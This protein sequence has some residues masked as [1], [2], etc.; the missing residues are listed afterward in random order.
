[1][2][3]PDPVLRSERLLLRPLTAAD[4]DLGRALL[5]DPEV[6][7]YM[8]G[9]YSAQRLEQEMA[10][11]TRRC[12]AGAIGV[13]C[14]LDAAGEE[15][16]GTGALLPLPIEA[17]DTEWDL[18]AG[19]ALPDR[20]IE[21]GY[22]LKREA[23]GRGYATEI[24]RRLLRFAFEETALDQVV[25]VVDPANEVSQKVL[26]KAGFSHEGWRRAYAAEVPG[27]RITRRQWLAG[28]V[29]QA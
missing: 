5:L 22:L 16:L 28:R 23:W 14:A 11:A 19:D 3:K 18:I 29:D 8:G 27:F 25:A 10:V 4:E 17:D 13:W 21:I 24:C 20:E 26:R 2:T 7:R 9:T 6:M 15:K 1:M 12:A